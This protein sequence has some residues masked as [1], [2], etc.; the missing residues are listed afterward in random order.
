[1]SEPYDGEACTIS[2]LRMHRRS[3]TVTRFSAYQEGK[4]IC[5]NV[6]TED[7]QYRLI[8]GPDVFVNLQQRKAQEIQ[9]VLQVME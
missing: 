5:A 4:G 9:K 3:N 2:I 1:M 7:V 6:K 8:D